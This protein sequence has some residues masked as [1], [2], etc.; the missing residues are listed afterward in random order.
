MAARPSALDR[1]GLVTTRIT[2]LRS[3]IANARSRPR[4]GTP[5]DPAPRGKADVGPNARLPGAERENVVWATIVVVLASG[6]GTGPNNGQNALH[7]AG[8]RLASA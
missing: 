3:G 6:G 5:D 7:P 1:L 8:P 4:A 2:E